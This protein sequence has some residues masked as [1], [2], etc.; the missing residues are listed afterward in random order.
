MKIR[1]V[2]EILEACEKNICGPHAHDLPQGHIKF[3]LDL[4]EETKER[5]LYLLNSDDTLMELDIPDENKKNN[6]D[7]E[8][9]YT[10]WCRCTLGACLHLDLHGD[11]RQ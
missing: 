9:D 10:M 4:T 7:I 1:R 8:Y 3:Y 6:I 11:E 5:L 2:I